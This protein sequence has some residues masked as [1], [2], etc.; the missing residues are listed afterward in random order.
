MSEN[1]SDN[2]E[3]VAK[4]L[5]VDQ[6]SEKNIETTTEVDG[7]VENQD[8]TNDNNDE[9]SLCL[10][11]SSSENPLLPSHQC[12]QCKKDAWKLCQCCHELLLSRSCPIC[13]GDYA[14]IVMCTV[15]GL[16]FVR[17]ADNQLAAE[18]KANLLY[19][20]GVIRQLIGKSNV[21]VWSPKSNR[22]F[23]SLPEKTADGSADDGS[24]AIVSIPIRSEQ[25]SE[26]TFLFTN[27]IWDEIE[28]EVEHGEVQAGEMVTLQRAI[29]WILAITKEDGHK[30]F[31]MMNAEDWNFMLNP[32]ESSD[33]VEALKAI[34]NTILQPLLR[35]A[36]DGKLTNN[37]NT[38]NNNDIA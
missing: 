37:N 21:C 8:I 36:G 19:K 31:T 3:H 18:E 22:M 13:R 15:P 35:S 28:N 30:L 11:H 25:V 14:P 38:N 6:E 10:N 9:C 33:T 17:L 26:D 24:F 1:D 29:Q 12:P 4:R 23:F 16:S 32:Q 27:K 34:R 2:N 5:K 20:F 7:E